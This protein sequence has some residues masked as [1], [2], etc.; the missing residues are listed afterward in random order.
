[1]Y[2][3]LLCRHRDLIFN[4]EH[5]LKNDS[6]AMALDSRFY[7]SIGGPVPAAAIATGSTSNTSNIS[8]SS[9]SPFSPSSTNYSTSAASTAATTVSFTSASAATLRSTASSPSLRSRESV[10]MP[11]GMID[12][13]GNTA[14]GG[15]VRVVVRVRGF[16]PRGALLL[17]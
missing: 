15:N 7:V 17:G 14:R 12:G 1:M 6:R 16:L 5:I 2:H 4:I 3:N 13:G 11:A 8:F 10:V 9:S